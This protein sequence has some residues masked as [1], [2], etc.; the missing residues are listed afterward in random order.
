MG[1]RDRVALVAASSKGLGRE[2]ARSL[3]RQG[4][5]I[6]VCA[7][8]EEALGETAEAI[9]SEI[10]AEVLDVVAD[11][12]RAEDIK[13]LIERTLERFGAIDILINNCGGPPAGTFLDHSLDRWRAAVENNLVSAVALTKE[14]VPSMIKQ[15]WGRIV[16][17]TSISVKQPL[18]NLM[19]SNSIRAAV[20]GWA[21]TLA[22]ELG[23]HS[24]TVNSICQG[25]FLTDRLAELAAIKA[26]NAGETMDAV[27]GEWTSEV[28]LGRIG[29]PEEF[30][31]LVA[32]LAS[33]KAAYIT[34][35]TITI[36]GGLCQGLL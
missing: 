31:D 5:R 32:F 8:G 34:G 2:S 13:N 7:R 22:T 29:N 21:K 3:A 25:Y 26:K 18:P 12:T 16:N 14:I 9:R 23:P 15:K 4:A 10:G 20:V 33:E 19:L 36:D 1:I 17:V 11:L 6:V 28:P 24:I 30:G 35:T 27:F